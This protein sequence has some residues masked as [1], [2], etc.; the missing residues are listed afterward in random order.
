MSL[1]LLAVALY[2]DTSR[3]IPF[4][5]GFDA[6]A[7]GA[8]FLVYVLY[9]RDCSKREQWL[10]SS[11]NRAVPVPCQVKESH[12]CDIRDSSDPEWGCCPAVE[13]TYQRNGSTN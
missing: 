13:F 5:L 2:Q 1:L 3:G 7:V 11:A 6:I 12:V 9:R 4:L 8:G 10:R